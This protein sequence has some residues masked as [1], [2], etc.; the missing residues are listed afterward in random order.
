[1]RSHLLVV[2]GL[3]QESGFPVGDLQG[4]TASVRGDDGRPLVQRLADFDLEAFAGGELQRD[5]CAGHEGVEDLVRGADAHDDDVGLE[6][7]VLRCEGVHGFLVDAERVGVV[8]CAVAGDDEL[9]GVLLGDVFHVRAA[10]FGVRGEH[11]RN[12]LCGVEACDLHDVLAGGVVEG[13]H[14]VAEALRFEL[15]HVVLDVPVVHLLVQAIEPV[16]SSRKVSH[17]R[18]CYGLGHELADGVADE[19][20]GLLDVAPDPIPDV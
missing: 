4:D 16:R 10:E 13:G 1:M 12:S 19:D 8:D 5:V 20:V 7:F 3:H 11:V 6:V 2:A 15:V 17:L 18:R 14:A 9:R